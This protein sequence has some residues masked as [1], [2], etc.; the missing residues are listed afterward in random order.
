MENK[1]SVN[2]E[3]ANAEV[4]KVLSEPKSIQKWDWCGISFG[5]SSR[6]IGICASHESFYK[7]I[8]R[9]NHGAFYLR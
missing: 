5:L 1:N 6:K 2:V 7:I 8:N 3:K 4:K 9:E